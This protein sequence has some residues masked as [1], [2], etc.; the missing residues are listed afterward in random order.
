MSPAP[1]GAALIELRQLSRTFHV[2]GRPVHAL[3]EV[4]LGL[5][6]G[7]YISI[8]GSSGSGKS[9]L[10]HLIGCL[11]RPTSGT[12]LLEGRDVGVLD[13]AALTHIRRHKMGFVFQAFHLVPR[14]S[15]AENVELPMIFAGIDA[16]ERRAR[17]GRALEAV[18]LGQRQ[19]HRP[20]QLSGGERQRVAMARAV[21]M[22][23]A[24][25]LAD[26][27]TGNLDS[28]SGAEVI[29]ILEELN[30]Q[31]LTLVLVT[32]DPS[33]AGRARRR[34]RMQDGRLL[35]DSARSAG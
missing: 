1:G 21:V 27:P 24:I 16:R 29:S 4:D 19:E 34:I 23:P 33:I 3:A 31:G 22:R 32:H 6:V 8:M 35:H 11:D 28:A 9:T 17:V 13:D 2:G 10:L 18:G 20:E 30:G 25:I 26:E 12:Y 14:L 15:A 5:Q 7:D